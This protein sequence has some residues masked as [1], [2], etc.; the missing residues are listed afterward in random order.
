MKL[1]AVSI[2]S[3]QNDFTSVKGKRRCILGINDMSCKGTTWEVLSCPSCSN[4]KVTNSLGTSIRSPLCIWTQQLESGKASSETL[5]TILRTKLNTYLLLS[6]LSIR[7]LILASKTTSILFIRLGIRLNTCCK[8]KAALLS[9]KVH[10]LRV[11]YKG[12]IS[13]HAYH[14]TRLALQVLTQE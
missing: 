10:M 4:I 3:L 11:R 5:F 8:G 14:S 12:S 2:I 6:Q 9:I 13:M 7:Q 1:W